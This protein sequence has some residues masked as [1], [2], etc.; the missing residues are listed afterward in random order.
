M[1]VLPLEAT[2]VACR[3]DLQLVDAM[4]SLERMLS[5]MHELDT[6]EL[7]TITRCSG[8]TTDACNKQTWCNI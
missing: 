3:R 7:L 8:Q 5:G 6:D 2:M 1:L 4:I